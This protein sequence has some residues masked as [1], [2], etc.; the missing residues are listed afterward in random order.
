MNTADKP[1]S[2]IKLL[3]QTAQAYPIITPKIFVLVVLSA[4]LQLVIPWLFVWKEPI[5][6]VGLLAFVLLTWFFYTAVLMTARAALMHQPLSYQ[7][8][9]ALARQRF[10]R[11]LGSNIIFF[12]VGAFALLFEFA[13]DLLFDLIHQSPFFVAISLAINVFVFVMLYFAIPLIVIE[14][15]TSI[16]PAFERSVRLV[17]HN[18][19]RT[20]IVLA[21]VGAIILGFEALGVLVTGQHRMLLFTVYHFVLQVI[22]YPLIVAATLVLLQ[23][24]QLRYQLRSAHQADIKQHHAH[25]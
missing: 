12:A 10:L 24:L 15:G 11:V 4:L 25:G 5:G 19:W 7:D 17:T 18:W 14:G 20:F 16:I 6:F 2:L 22:F 9:F 8:A 3:K 23:D 1:S 21:V 13:L